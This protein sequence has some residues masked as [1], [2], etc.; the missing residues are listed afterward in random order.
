MHI[1]FIRGKM[2]I[3]SWVIDNFGLLLTEVYRV[4][5]YQ[6]LQGQQILRMNVNVNV[7]IKNSGIFSPVHEQILHF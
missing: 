6:L 4:Q 3:T 7:E 2:T 1:Y 5:N